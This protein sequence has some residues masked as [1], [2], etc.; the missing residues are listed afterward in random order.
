MKEFA[1]LLEMVDYFEEAINPTRGKAK[2]FK[3]KMKPLIKKVKTAKIGDPRR[4]AYMMVWP[5]LRDELQIPELQGQDT[6]V[7]SALIQR[8]LEELHDAG[9][10]PDDAGDKFEAYAEQEFDDFVNRISTTKRKTSLKSHYKGGDVKSHIDVAG[11]GTGFTPGETAAERAEKAKLEKEIEQ[12]AA[13][14]DPDARLKQ[15]GISIDD[16]EDEFKDAVRDISDT[17]Q[18]QNTIMVEIIFDPADGPVVKKQAITGLFQGQTTDEPDINEDYTNMTFEIDPSSQLGQKIESA[19]AS[20]IET[21]LQDH[22]FDIENGREAKVIIHMP[23]TEDFLKPI[24]EPELDDT[25]IDDDEPSDEQLSDIENED[26]EDEKPWYGGKNEED[27]EMMGVYRSPYE[28]QR[29]GGPAQG[30]TVTQVNIGSNTYDVYFKGGQV[31]KVEGPDADFNTT[32]ITQKLKK[33]HKLKDALIT[34]KNTNR[35]PVP[36]M[37]SVLAYMP[38]ATDEDHEEPIFLETTRERYKPSTLHQLDE[39]RHMLG[40]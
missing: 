20:A 26:E 33:G 19:G 37:D 8:K 23:E 35:R 12:K 40:D 7:N 29:P 15:I 16:V 25:Y 9:K 6:P 5:F 10:I 11:K 1:E 31:V 21:M 38:P 17:L 3:A 2:D 28:Q 22:I 4:Y 13:Q 39:Y 30:D 32:A 36:M 34:S 18:P 24:K 27:A 14:G